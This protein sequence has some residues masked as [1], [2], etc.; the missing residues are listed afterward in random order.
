MKEVFKITGHDEIRK[1]LQELDA[2]IAAPALVSSM[3]SAMLVIQN[4]AKAN[5]VS[6]GMYDTG[7]LAQSVNR[8]KSIYSADNVACITVGINK[9]VKGT[10]RHGHV[11]WPAKYAHLIENGR[12]K[13]GEIKGSHFMKNA[14]ESKKQE[15]VNRMM[16]VLRRKVAK[17]TKEN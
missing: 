14:F 5:L 15:V 6:A 16:E 17:Y 7:L 3:N 13:R 9:K 1:A 8:A 2:D 11:R 4:Q 12:N 10:D